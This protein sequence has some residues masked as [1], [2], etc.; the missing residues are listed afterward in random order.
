[1]KYIFVALLSLFSVSLQ[2]SIYSPSV[3]CESKNQSASC[4]I[5]NHT[6]TVLSC[7]FLVVG[8]TQNGQLI[9]KMK[10]TVLH[11]EDTL[12]ISIQA[13]SKADQIKFANGEANCTKL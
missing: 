12:A 13:D 2:A 7:E 5:K 6:A 8:E 4:G 3:D 10:T 11:P 9:T 1:M